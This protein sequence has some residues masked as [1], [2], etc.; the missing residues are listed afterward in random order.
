VVEG[1][2]LYDVLKQENVIGSAEQRREPEIDFALPAARYFVMVHF[3]FDA[4]RLQILNDVRSQVVQRINWRQRHI[5]FFCSHS[6]TVIPF[7]PSWVP[8]SFARLKV[9]SGAVHV[10]V[11]ADLIEDKELR[12]RAEIAV[13]RKTREPEIVL[14]ACGDASRVH[15]VALSCYRIYNRSK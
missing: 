11:V 15:V 12:L 9:I 8:K 3:R 10:I 14:R 6:I 13:V 5:T 7:P 4:H 1:G 2:V